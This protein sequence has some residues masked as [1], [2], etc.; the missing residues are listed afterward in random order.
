MNDP[1]LMQISAL[2]VALLLLLAMLISR[3]RGN[4]MP[5]QAL[6]SVGWHGG[7]KKR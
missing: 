1:I 4:A 7:K 2:T 6:E 3:S 5:S